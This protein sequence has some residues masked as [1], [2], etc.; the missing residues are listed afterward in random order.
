MP[1][2]IDRIKTRTETTPAEEARATLDKLFVMLDL[3]DSPAQR[4]ACWELSLIHI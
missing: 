1:A 2:T 3:C 4:E